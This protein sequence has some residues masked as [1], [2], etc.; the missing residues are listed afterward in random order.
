VEHC[1]AEISTHLY[2]VN[3]VVS[4]LAVWKTLFQNGCSAFRTPAKI[5]I[6]L[7]LQSSVM[8]VLFQA[9]PGDLESAASNAL[10]LSISMQTPV[11]SIETSGGRSTCLW[12]M[13]FLL[14]QQF[15]LFFLGSSRYDKSDN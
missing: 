13:P 3:S 10:F 8:S 15:C 7:K 1:G 12:R 9:W 11:A 5:E 4:N 6:C 14:Q 2:A